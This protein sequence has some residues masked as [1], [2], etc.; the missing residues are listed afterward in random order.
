MQTQTQITA[1]ITLTVLIL[2]FTIILKILMHYMYIYIYINEYKITVKIYEYIV[3]ITPSVFDAL[4]Y[5]KETLKQ[6]G[7]DTSALCF[8]LRLI[9]QIC[10]FIHRFFS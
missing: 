10:H 8:K 7:H 5:V 9:A 3:T 1:Q 6:C 4:I 2:K